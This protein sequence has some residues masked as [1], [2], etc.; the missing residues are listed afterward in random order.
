ML[1]LLSTTLLLSSLAYATTPSE[2]IEDFL[3]DEFSDNPRLEAVEVKVDDVVP[4]KDLK[5]WNGYIVDVK[6]HLKS[7]PK[8]EIRQKMI[9]FSDGVMITKN[10]TNM[11]TLANMADVIKPTFKEGD[12]SKEN[13]LYGNKNAKHK[14]V[15]FS[16]PLCPFCRGFVP[17]AIKEM[18]ANP[19]KYAVYYYHLP[20][21]RIHP[22]SVTIVKAAIAA[23][24]QGVKDVVLKMYNI[25]VNPREKNVSK[26]LKAFNTAVGTDIT[27]KDI[28]TKEVKEVF[29]KDIQT[30]RDLLVSGTPTVY[31]DGKIDKTKKK[32]KTVK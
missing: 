6:A 26:I 1:R 15:L 32:Y 30:A 2:K 13:L 7:N 10:L 28:E 12:Y 24:K 8:N 27:K 19:E 31:L 20:L 3:S 16:D 17:G 25:K 5:G 18:K 11:D 29:E 22:A 21:E 14:V 23:E 4:L 9:W